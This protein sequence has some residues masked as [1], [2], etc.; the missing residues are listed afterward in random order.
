MADSFSKKEREKKKIQKKKDKEERKQFR[1]DNPDLS[2]PDNI[3]YVDEYGNIS[4]TPPDLSKKSAINPDDILLGAAKR[5]EVMPEDVVRRG[6]VVLYNSSKG[7]G[8][9][10]DDKSQES[11][12]VHMSALLEPIKEFDVVNFELGKGPK[13]TVAINVRLFEKNK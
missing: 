9:I 12:F 4:S 2:N 10:R 6:K 1:K 8:F 11:I 3:S 13:G 5:E 7:Y